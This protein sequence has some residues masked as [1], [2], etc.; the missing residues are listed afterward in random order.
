MHH[1]FKGLLQIFRQALEP[2]LVEN[3]DKQALG[4]IKLGKIF[5]DL[6][7]LGQVADDGSMIQTVDNALLESHMHVR[8]GHDHRVKSPGLVAELVDGGFGDAEIDG[9]GILDR[10]HGNRGGPAVIAV[11]GDIQADD[12]LMIHG[13]HEVIKKLSAVDKLVQ[14]VKRVDQKRQVDQSEPG[15]QVGGRHGTDA[16]ALNGAHLQLIQNLDFASQGGKRLKININPAV[17]RFPQSVTHGKP[18]VNAFDTGMRNVG[19]DTFIFSPGG[20]KIRFPLVH[21]GFGFLGRRFGL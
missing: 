8:P 20:I 19:N 21:G 16:H 3:P 9:L 17:G 14:L 12:P 15:P 10:F 4:V 11:A 2:V 7:L 6:K 5:A 1:F 13:V 18:G